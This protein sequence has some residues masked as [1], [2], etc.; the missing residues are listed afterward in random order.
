M[1]GT[2]WEPVP[3]SVRESGALWESVPRS[4]RESGTLWESVP[5]SVRESGTLWVSVFYSLPKTDY[6]QMPLCRE[7]SD[8]KS[9]VI[10]CALKNCGGG[11]R[12]SHQKMRGNGARKRAFP[13]DMIC[14]F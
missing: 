7:A 9:A 10:Y 11:G 3:R 8:R 6:S 4:V 5:R 12:I 2:L 14:D 1:S 13:E